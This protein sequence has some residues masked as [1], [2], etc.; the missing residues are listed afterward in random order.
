MV[1]HDV[2]SGHVITH[3]TKDPYYL[4]DVRVNVTQL[5]T[6]SFEDC[7]SQYFKGRF[8]FIFHQAR[9]SLMTIITLSTL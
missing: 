4:G 8:Y 2:T 1:A 5:K 7:R 3:L 6:V 9:Q